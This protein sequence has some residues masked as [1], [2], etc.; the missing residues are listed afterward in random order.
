MGSGAKPL[1][2]EKIMGCIVNVKIFTLKFETLSGG[3]DDA[4]VRTFIADKEVL[5]IHD[6]AFVHHGLAPSGAGG[7]VP[8]QLRKCRARRK[9]TYQRTG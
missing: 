6:H 2:G 7:A 3:F 9:D 8:R 1:G 4:E 5:S